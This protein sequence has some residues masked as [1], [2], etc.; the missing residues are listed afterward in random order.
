MPAFTTYTNTQ[1][2]D[3]INYALSLSDPSVRERAEHKRA[4]LVARRVPEL[5]K[6]LL[7]D[8][9][10]KNGPDTRLVVSPLWWRDHADP[11][12][13]V[14][15]V[16]DG[17]SLAIRLTWLDRS[18]NDSIRRP[19]DFEDMAAVQ[20][21]KG[22]PEPFVGMGA[23]PSKAGSGRGVDLWLWRAA[24]NRSVAA[25]DSMLDDYPFDMP[26]YRDVNKGQD[27]R[28]PDFLTARAAGNLIADPAKTQAGSTMAAQGFGSVTFRPRTS[29]FVT[30]DATGKD[31]R[32]TVILRRPLE[33]GPDD[34]VSLAPGD[35]CSI[36]FALWDGAANDRNGQ[37]LVTIWH[38][39]KIE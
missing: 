36:A 12:L 29:Q 21:Y 3:L 4:T 33:V 10:G 16:H 14:A 8:G 26:H 30:A 19:E 32:W 20:L 1:M 2:G 38:D 17:K 13:H 15:A 28:P 22:R 24:W 25:A 11:D 18:R 39:L 7:S 9:T 34:G 23:L 31:G 35:A 27:F 37:K 5:S 6:E